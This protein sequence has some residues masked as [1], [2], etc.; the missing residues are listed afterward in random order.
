MSSLSM[1]LLE[2][3]DWRLLLRSIRDGQCILLLG[4][5]AAVDPSDPQGDPLPAR[6]ALKL[7]EELH[8]AGKG[9]EIVTASDLA[10]IAQIYAQAMPKKRPGLWLTAAKLIYYV[11]DIVCHIDRRYKAISP[12]SRRT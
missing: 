10:H 8:Q 5:G 4:P 6:L 7:T 12:H 1:S 2:E 11:F 3:R 9:G